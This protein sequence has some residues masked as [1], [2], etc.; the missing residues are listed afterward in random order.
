MSTQFVHPGSWEWEYSR[1]FGFPVLWSVRRGEDIH[2]GFH[3]INS[4]GANPCHR[5]IGVSSGP[6]IENLATDALSWSVEHLG[7][8]SLS[9]SLYFYILSDLSLPFTILCIT[10]WAPIR[11]SAY[12]NNPDSAPILL[13]ILEDC[14]SWDSQT[15][16]TFNVPQVII[17]AGWPKFCD[18]K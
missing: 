13:V 3:W 11:D 9:L 14:R 6:D 10:H 2:S 5:W 4:L 16:S 17:I 18:S 8:M 12:E 1:L 15:G 7:A